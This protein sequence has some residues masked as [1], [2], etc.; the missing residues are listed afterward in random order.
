MS[1][2]EGGDAE[3]YEVSEYRPREMPGVGDVLLSW[4]AV[5]LAVV[6]LAALWAWA[7]G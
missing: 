7:S 6:I 2:D 3:P 1:D 4:E 5:G